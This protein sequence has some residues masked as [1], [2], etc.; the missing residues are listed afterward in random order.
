MF[1]CVGKKR[2]SSIELSNNISD[3]SEAQGTGI[4]S[5]LL[6][7]ERR[8][9]TGKSAIYYIIDA[10]KSV[11]NRKTRFSQKKRKQKTLQCFQFQ[12]GSYRTQKSSPRKAREK[13]V[14]M[15]FHTK[16]RHS[17]LS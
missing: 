15:K 11:P 9:L 12:N 2:R 10:E 3:R 13:S 14:K 1:L 4:L 17:V 8:E 7:G 16:N 6:L 5:D